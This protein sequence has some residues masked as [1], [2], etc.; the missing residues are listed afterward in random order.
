MIIDLG[1][2]LLDNL[3][4]L[5]LSGVAIDWK[6]FDAP[7][8][9]KKVVLPTYPFQRQRYWAKA[10]ERKSEV[11]EEFFEIQWEQ[12]PIQ[13]SDAALKTYQI[14]TDGSELAQEVIAALQQRGDTVLQESEMAAHA[15][16]VLYF[17]K[18]ST[19]DDL[20]Q[21]Y[22]AALQLIQTAGA[23]EKP[24]SISLITRNASSNLGQSSLIGLRRVAASNTRISSASKSIAI[25]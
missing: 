17:A 20:E 9:R 23:R 18:E 25:P 5:Y 3:S 21:N 1:A 22:L 8:Q 4:R 15:D 12:K 19:A 24:P 7:Y 10:L 2:P 13:K 6:G 11:L 14:F 16:Q